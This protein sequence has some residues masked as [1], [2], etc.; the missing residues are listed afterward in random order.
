MVRQV[1]ASG[2]GVKFDAAALAW[3]KITIEPSNLEGEIDPLDRLDATAKVYDKLKIKPFWWILEVL[4]MSYVWQDK[5]G[6]WR[7]TFK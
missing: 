5:N 3:A 2:C 4:R 1:A 7:K 6:I